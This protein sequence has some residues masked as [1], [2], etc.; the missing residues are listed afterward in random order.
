ML[1]TSPRPEIANGRGNRVAA[2]APIG[3]GKR[4]SLGGA[5]AA[6]LETDDDL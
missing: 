3:G 4:S 2:R 5:V 1:L 6:L